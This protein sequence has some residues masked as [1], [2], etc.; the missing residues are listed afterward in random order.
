MNK[1]NTQRDSFGDMLRIEKENLFKEEE[2]SKISNERT[3]GKDITFAS[4][5]LTEDSSMI[6]V[7]RKYKCRYQ[8]CCE[9][10]EYTQLRLRHEK[11]HAEK[12]ENIEKVTIKC[13]CCTPPM[14]FESKKEKNNH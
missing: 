8:G 10:F 12:N 13:D 1:T 2:K 7:N 11:K 14:E 9:A 3:F 4:T 5:N 6:G